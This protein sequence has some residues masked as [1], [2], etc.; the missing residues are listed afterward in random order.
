MILATID[1]IPNR[2]YE[3]LGIVKG[4]MVQTKNMF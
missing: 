4:N 1:N 2:K 3:V